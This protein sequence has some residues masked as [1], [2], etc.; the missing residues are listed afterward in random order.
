MSS[1]WV[2][3]LPFMGT[4]PVKH[5]CSASSRVAALKRS[6]HDP[7]RIPEAQETSTDGADPT[8]QNTTP[9][10]PR[11]KKRAESSTKDET[12]RPRNQTNTPEPGQE[13]KFPTKGRFRLFVVLL[14]AVTCFRR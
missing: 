5:S 13:A 6:G 11:G 3:S 1:S 12:D 14:L 9:E 4:V 8:T 10:N 2:C 7:G